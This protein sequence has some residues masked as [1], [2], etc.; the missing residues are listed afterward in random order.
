LRMVRS[1]WMRRALAVHDVAVKALGAQ[2]H[3]IV[4]GYGRSGQSLARLLQREGIRIMALDHDPQRVKEAAAAGESVVFGDAER[5]EVLL[6]AGIQRAVAVVISFAQTESA[7]RILSHARDLAPGVPI[8]VRTFD[9]SDLGR[10][11]NAGATEVV[12]EVAEGAL[13][14]ASHAMLLA[15]LPLARVLKRIRETRRTRYDL[16]R[17]FFP[18]AS[19]E[20]TD[21][22]DVAQPRL[23]SVVLARQAFGTG[24]CLGDLALHELQVEVT[25]LRRANRGAITPTSELVL[26]VNDVV[27]LLGAP[28]RI[29]LAEERLLRGPK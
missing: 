27:V 20:E 24:R 14:L 11:Q 25:A 29:A 5:R 28:D 15:G 23:H 16:M 21:M 7:L 2:N 9:D 6:A 18:G 3:V 8:I 12:P 26:E 10:L 4:C 1:E 19:D 17:G 13:M 22:E